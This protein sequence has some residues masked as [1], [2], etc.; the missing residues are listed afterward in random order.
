MLP[1]IGLAA[2]MGVTYQLQWLFIP[3]ISGSMHFMYRE[4]HLRRATLYFD[5]QKLGKDMNYMECFEMIKEVLLTDEKLSL[6]I[7]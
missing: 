4:K 3:I 5:L 1:H 2:L 7:D 6:Y